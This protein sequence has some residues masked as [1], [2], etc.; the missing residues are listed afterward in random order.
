MIKKFF[1][2]TICIIIAASQFFT[3]G[4]SKDE[5]VTTK[6]EITGVEI[7]AD[8]SKI[9]YRNSELHIEAQIVAATRIRNV[10]LEISPRISGFGWV[11]SETYTEGFSG[12]KNA[13]FHKHYRVPSGA[14]GGTY[15]VLLIVNDENGTQER[16]EDTLRI[17]TNPDLPATS[18]MAATL[19]GGQ[20]NVTGNITAPKKLAKISIEVQSATWTRNFEYTDADLV[21]KTSYTLNKTIDMS[22]APAGAHYHVNITVYDQAGKERFT[23]LHIN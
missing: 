3:L 22:T 8:H 9:T 5:T 6:T 18:G 14:T 16:Y 1:S 7:A 17:E 11:V 20:L 12:F 21:G 19:K 23:Q 13:E 2:N 10:Q 4:C 15:D